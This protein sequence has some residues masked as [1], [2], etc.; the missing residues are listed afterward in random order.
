M[1]ST[2]FLPTSLQMKNMHFLLHEKRNSQKEQQ[3]WKQLQQAFMWW[4]SVL[5]VAFICQ[6]M[7]ENCA[8]DYFPARIANYQFC[9]ERMIRSNLMARLTLNPIMALV[10]HLHSP[11][12]FLPYA[13]HAWSVTPEL[14]WRTEP[15]ARLQSAKLFKWQLLWASLLESCTCCCPFLPLNTIFGLTRFLDS[16]S[17]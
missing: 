11:L 13:P 9:L 4:V 3:F 2:V 16:G 1:F 12:P 7:A 8:Y 14:C 17:T 5:S 15:A 6:T 10:R